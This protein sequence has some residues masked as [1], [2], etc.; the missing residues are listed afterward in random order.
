MS[1]WLHF[2]IPGHFSKSF[3]VWFCYEWRERER[4][5]EREMKAKSETFCL[6]RHSFGSE[7]F[8]LTCTAIKQTKDVNKLMAAAKMYTFKKS[9]SLMSLLFFTFD[10]IHIEFT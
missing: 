7:V 2:E 10:D 1:V 3:F 5:R 9:I 6:F 4:E 8:Q